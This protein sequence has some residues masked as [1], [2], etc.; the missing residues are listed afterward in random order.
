MKYDVSRVE[1]HLRA[2]KSGSS[3][4]GVV[5][6]GGTD[7]FVLRIGDEKLASIQVD[8]VSVTC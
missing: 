3:R 8:L 6:L 1:R 4:Q 2:G 7:H 5:V